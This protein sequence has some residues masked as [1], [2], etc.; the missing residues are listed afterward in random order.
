MQVGRCEGG[1]ASIWG[2]TA[3]SPVPM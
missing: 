1:K 3:P 2:A